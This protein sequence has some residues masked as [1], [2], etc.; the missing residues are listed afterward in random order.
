M[1]IFELIQYGEAPARSL[2]VNH[3]AC[4]GLLIALDAFLKELTE[5]RNI[6]LIRERA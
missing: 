3:N 5:G 4:S 1:T 2:P 6:L